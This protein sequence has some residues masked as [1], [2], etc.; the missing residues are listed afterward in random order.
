[1]KEINVFDQVL[2]KSEGRLKPLRFSKF[3]HS[4]RRNGILALYHS[5]THQVI[6]LDDN[7]FREVS[8][9]MKSKESQE[10]VRQDILEELIKQ[11]FLVS[12]DYN[13]KRKIQEV[14]DRFLGKPI[15]RILYLLLTDVCNLRCR[16]CFIEGAMPKDHAFSWMSEETAIKGLN[17]FSQLLERNPSDRKFGP[18]SIFFYG[19]EPL[20]NQK[21]FLSALNEITRLKKQGGLPSDVSVS[22]L[23][24]ATVLKREVLKSIVEN[25]VGVS[26]SLDGP[27][28]FHDANRM[29]ANQ[30]GTFQTVIENVQRLQ[31]EG[32]NVSISCTISQKNLDQLEEVFQWMVSELQLKGLGFNMLLDLPGVVQSDEEYA[33]KATEK[34]IACYQVARERG[35]YEDRIMRK[36]KAFVKK[37]LH[38]V[39]CGGCGNQIVIAPNGRIGPCHGYMS[40]GRFFPGDI[41][42]SN[43]DPFQDPVFIEWSSRSPFNISKCHF[44][45]AIGLCGGGCPYNAELKSGSIWGIDH[46]FCTHSKNVLEWLIWDLFE[47]TKKGGEK[48]QE[49][50]F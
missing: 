28:D 8:K 35:I 4:F 50:E 14:C 19:G 30:K 41:N 23:T 48:C 17:F 37:S 47:K 27:K 26:V 16:Y 13:E 6:Y 32:V 39:D 49:A 44:C 29:F 18:P 33:K 12:L 45:E 22:L 24:N 9:R 5:L 21:V 3:V 43:F 40:S 15:F 31:K 42:D 10:K 20:L 11:G 36:I 7:V 1:M 46:N 2:S 34:I 25:K 38:L